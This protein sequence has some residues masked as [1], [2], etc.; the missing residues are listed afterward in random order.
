M[1]LTRLG[2]VIILAI[3][4]GAAIA[5]ALVVLESGSSGSKSSATVPEMS[6]DHVVDYV[7]YGAVTSI[8]ATGSDLTVH[9]REDVDTSG[10]NTKSHT[11]HSTPPPGQTATQAIEAAGFRVNG[12]GGLTVVTH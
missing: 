8:E 11:F 10:L 4:G 6:F 12:P 3:M 2:Y 5:I 9:I 1:A 7:R